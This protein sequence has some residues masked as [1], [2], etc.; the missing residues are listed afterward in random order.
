ME[1]KAVDAWRKL[2]LESLNAARMLTVDHVRAM[3][4]RV[5]YAAF[6]RTHALLIDQGQSPRRDLGTWSHGDLPRLVTVHLEGLMGKNAMKNYRSTLRTA[7]SFRS[8]AD[9]EPMK[10][11]PKQEALKV[12]QQ[13]ERLLGEHQ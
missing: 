3:L 7:R 4:N 13:V 11:I 9:Y 12:F 5:Y 8:M 1:Q 10:V 6:A 2:S